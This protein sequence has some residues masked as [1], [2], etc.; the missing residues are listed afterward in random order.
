MKRGLL[1]FLISFLISFFILWV[2]VSA[3]PLPP[4]DKYDITGT[5][6]ELQWYPEKRIKGIPQMSGS[7][8]YDRT[9]PAHFI[10]KLINYSGIDSATATRITRYINPHKPASP[11]YILLKINHENP[12]YLNKGMKIKVI[13]YTIRGDEGGTYTSYKR[14][15]IISP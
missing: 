10:V 4:L 11:L 7:A 15:I 6:S 3:A 14:I 13:E 8:G 2:E 12:Y 1:P 5:I 9:M